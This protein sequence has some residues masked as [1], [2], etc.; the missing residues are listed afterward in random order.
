MSVRNE[1]RAIQLLFWGVF[2]GNER[3]DEKTEGHFSTELTDSTGSVQRYAV[4]H[5]LRNKQEQ[6]KKKLYKND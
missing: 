1:Q 4:R 3:N 6:E 5:F 2:F